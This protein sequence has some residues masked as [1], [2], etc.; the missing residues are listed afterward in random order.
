MSEC[1]EWKCFFSKPRKSTTNQ[2]PTQPPHS[3][4]PLKLQLTRHFHLNGFQSWKKPWVVY[5]PREETKLFY[6]GVVLVVTHRVTEWARVTEQNTHYSPLRRNW[7]V[8]AWMTSDFFN[9]N[10]LFGR[11]E[12][13]KERKQKALHIGG[14]GFAPL[15]Q[16]FLIPVQTKT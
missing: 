3:W 15:S 8:L 13:K 11:V 12:A 4:K 6:W 1:K 7:G 16:E 9:F 14:K 10:W 5:V 2:N